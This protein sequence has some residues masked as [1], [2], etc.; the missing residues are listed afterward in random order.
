M[1]SNPLEIL[2]RLGA[3]DHRQEKFVSFEVQLKRPLRIEYQIGGFL[4]EEESTDKG[5][6]Q[7][8]I[9]LLGG[10][11]SNFSYSM[12]GKVEYPVEFA[13]FNCEVMVNPSAGSDHIEFGIKGTVGDGRL[14]SSHL[15][16][17]LHI[18]SQQAKEILERKLLAN[19]VQRELESDSRDP[20][21]ESWMR[22]T[23]HVINYKPYPI[24][25]AGEHPIGFEII[26]VYG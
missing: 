4:D 14:E 25:R 5:T 19:G 26:R 8:K 15:L 23:L 9:A 17:R 20:D 2:H 10:V 6:F 11:H 7:K 18:T 24:Q 21:S 16:F 12:I 3:S 22:L 1:A 13:N